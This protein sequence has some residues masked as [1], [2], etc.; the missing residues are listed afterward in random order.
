MKNLLVV[1]GLCSLLLIAC[2]KKE[3]NSEKSLLTFGFSKADNPGLI[4]DVTGKIEGS[5]IT[6]KV[7]NNTDL[8]QLIANFSASPTAAV[9]INSVLQENHKSANS[10]AS[11]KTITVLAED[12]STTNYTVT[13]TPSAESVEP[14]IKNQWV[15]FTYPYNAYFPYIATS[16]N[17][18]NGREG[19]ACGPTALAKILHCLKYPVNGTGSVDYTDPWGLHY[20]CDLT[21]LNLDYSNMPAKLK[22]SDPES[23]YKDVARLFLAAGSASFYLKIWAGTV[24][25]ELAPGLVQFFKLDPGLRLVNSW[26]ITKDQWISTLKAE[27]LAGRPVMI[28]GRTPASPAPGQPGNVAG[29]WFNVDGFNTQGKFHVVYNYGGIEGYFDADNLGGVYTAYNQAII[30]WKAK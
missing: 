13:V 26:E 25:T 17:I 16:T 22:S 9:K 19:N 14:I 30:G 24:S 27:F 5:S 21:T 7:S 11:P 15:T 10:Y 20:V 1:A 12:G 18:I 3:L 6:V 4:E 23:A 2:S 8:S 29:H 28:A